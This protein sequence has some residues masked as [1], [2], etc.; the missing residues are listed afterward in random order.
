MGNLTG[1]GYYPNCLVG[2]G[3]YPYP[4]HIILKKKKNLNLFY[5]HSHS[6]SLSLSKH[7]LQCHSLMVAMVVSP[8]VSSLPLLIALGD[9]LV[10]FVLISSFTCIEC[11]S[12]KEHLWW[13]AFKSSLTDIPLVFVVR[14]DCTFSDIPFVS[15]CPMISLSVRSL[16]FCSWIVIFVSL[17]P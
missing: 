12:L 10:P 8:L 9:V 1:Y 17:V 2:Y 13:Y 3:Y 5:R 6:L 4:T 7:L 14:S 15:F 11:Y 16:I